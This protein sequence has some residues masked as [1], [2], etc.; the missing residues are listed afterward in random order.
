LLYPILHGCCMWDQSVRAV[1]V[2]ARCSTC[3]VVGGGGMALSHVCPEPQAEAYRMGNENYPRSCPLTVLLF[4]A[5]HPQLGG[6]PH[7]HV[8]ANH[9]M[10]DLCRMGYT[11][12]AF[13]LVRDST[14]SEVRLMLAHFLHVARHTILV[15]VFKGTGT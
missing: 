6:E 11:D 15:K 8:S 4:P 7:C 14:S 13:A 1:H 2:T 9:T 3:T 5:P 12:S 10:R